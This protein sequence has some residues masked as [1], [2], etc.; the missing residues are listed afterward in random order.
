MRNN[1]KQG[2]SPVMKWTAAGIA[3]VVLLGIGFCVEVEATRLGITVE[4]VQIKRLEQDEAAGR[5]DNAALKKQVEALAAKLKDLEASH[6]KAEANNAA[7]KTQV[8]DT[9]DKQAAI[10]TAIDT[11]IK[12]HR[13]IDGMTVKQAE[14]AIGEKFYERESGSDE[15]VYTASII[16]KRDGPARLVGNLLTSSYTYG[17]LYTLTVDAGGHI[18]HWSEEPFQKDNGVGHSS[19]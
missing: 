8:E 3:A 2:F 14:K 12:E 6:E 1:S 15:T 4:A 10:D 19:Q 16:T 11:A 13:I 18:T 7:L 9:M 17:N 5:A